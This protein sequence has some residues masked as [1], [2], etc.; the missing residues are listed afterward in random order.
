VVTAAALSCLEVAVV[1]AF[2]GGGEGHPTTLRRLITAPRLK[3]GTNTVANGSCFLWVRAP[4]PPTRF[5]PLPTRT[6][7][8]TDVS[9]LLK[10]VSIGT[11]NVSHPGTTTTMLFV[12][13]WCF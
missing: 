2:G 11:R 4:P 13:V 6:L 9:A 5:G 12:A 1:V 10:L 7:F 8:R 3:H